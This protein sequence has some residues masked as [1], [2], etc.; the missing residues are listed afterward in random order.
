MASLCTLLSAKGIVV[1]FSTWPM[2]AS[3]EFKM[4]SMYESRLGSSILATIWTAWM[5][6]RAE[7]SR[8]GR[9][10]RASEPVVQTRW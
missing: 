7:R 10:S 1:S 6:M 8:A 2:M 4:R 5:L 3:F 9:I